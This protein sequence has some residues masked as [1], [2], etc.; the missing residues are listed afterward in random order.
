MTKKFDKV[1]ISD[2]TAYYPSGGLSD[3]IAVTEDFQ[4]A[5]EYVAKYLMV[6]ALLEKEKGELVTQ[7][8]NEIT[9]QQLEGLET[10]DYVVKEE[11][12]E[13]IWEEIKENLPEEELEEFHEELEDKFQEILKQRNN[14]EEH[15][16]TKHTILTAYETGGCREELLQA[17][18]YV[19]VEIEEDKLDKLFHLVAEEEFGETRVVLEI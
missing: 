16:W 18:A 7:C 3:I 11:Y 8:M 2:I 5:K 1:V 4:K 10:V 6:V 12:F 17:L 13:D 15:L 14:G 9:V 19:E